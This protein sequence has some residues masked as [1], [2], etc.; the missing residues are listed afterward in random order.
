MVF[1]YVVFLLE[2]FV[3]GVIVRIL[4]VQIIN[5]QPLKHKFR[6]KFALVEAVNVFLIIT[7]LILT[8]NFVKQVADIFGAI[9][10]FRG[11]FLI[12]LV[13]DFPIE[14]VGFNGREMF[15]YGLILYLIQFSQM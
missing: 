2:G 4:I 5:L 7:G 10:L 6:F 11:A 13:C 1:R 15:Q 9:Y 12:K 14:S 8:G 3:F